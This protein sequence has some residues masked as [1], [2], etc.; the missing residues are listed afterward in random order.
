MGKGVA[1]PDPYDGKPFGQVDLWTYDQYHG[2]TY[3]YYLEALMVFG[4]IT[5][6]DPRTL[7]DKERAAD[8]L[9]ISPSEAVAL[10]RI[11]SEQLAKG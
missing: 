9:G 11:A 2:S 8:E 3:G 4:K 6:V 1:D 7:G 5:G 10:Q